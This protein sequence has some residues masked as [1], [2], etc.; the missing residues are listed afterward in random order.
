VLRLLRRYAKPLTV[1]VALLLPLLVYRANAI[2]PADANLLDRL[3]LLLTAPIEGWLSAAT[4]FA[5]DTVDR[6][7]D[8]VNAR[9]ENV[10]LRRALAD[11]D[12]ERDRLSSLDGENRELRRLLALKELNP[13]AQWVAAQVIGAGSSPLSRTIDIDRGSLDGL[14]RGATVLGGQGLVGIVRRVGWTSAEVQLIADEKIAFRAAVARTRAKG[15]VRGQGHAAAFRLIL[16]EVLRSDDLAV[17]DRV[18]TSGLDGVFPKGVPVGVVVAIDDDPAV[19]HRSATLEP[20]V[21]FARLEAV[22]VLV[23]PPKKAEL[24][25]PEPLLPPSLRPDFDGGLE[26]SDAGVAEDASVPKPPR[27]AAKPTGN[28]RDAGVASRDGGGVNDGGGKDAAA[29]TTSSQGASP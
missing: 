12:R 18:E 27:P 13:E 24:A 11:A 17:G 2:R 16:G 21:D 19:Q 23:V 20:Y 26:V 29:T 1:V 15:R 25:T 10:S 5:S 3:V 8:V 4:S 9:E 28:D 14:R 7:L 22:S 6:Y